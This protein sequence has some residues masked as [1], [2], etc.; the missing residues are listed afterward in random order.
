MFLCSKQLLIFTKSFH[1]TVFVSETCQVLVL[2][3]DSIYILR[4]SILDKLL[5]GKIAVPVIQ[6]PRKTVGCFT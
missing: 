4:F 3:G 5:G 2:Y 1:L 6:I